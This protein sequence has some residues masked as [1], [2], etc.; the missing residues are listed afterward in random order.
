[1]MLNAASAS[2]SRP[3][4]GFE[5]FTPYHLQDER[6]EFDENVFSANIADQEALWGPSVTVATP[7][8]P[9]LKTII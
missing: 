2:P 4:I 5:H 9:R 8:K 6:E 1:M 7:P 3:D